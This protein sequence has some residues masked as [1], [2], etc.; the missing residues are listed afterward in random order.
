MLEGSVFKGADYF[1]LRMTFKSSRDGKVF[2][3]QVNDIV[4]SFGGTPNPQKMLPV[5]KLL[6]GSLAEEIRIH[7]IL[8]YIPAEPD[9]QT[10]SRR[11]SFYEKVDNMAAL[12]AEM[13]LGIISS[14]FTKFEF[15]C[16]GTPFGLISFSTHQEI[17]AKKF[18]SQGYGIFLGKVEDVLAR[19]DRF[20]KMVTDLV[21]G[22]QLR[23][24]M[25]VR[26]RR[27]VDGQG[28]IRVSN[29]IQGLIN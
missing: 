2:K 21:S 27:L 13:D 4:L 11:V 19:S 23:K 28:S 10:F 14:G 12:I 26:S 6:D 22:V 5:V 1:P 7:A 20:H 18:S 29:I 3:S 8:G 15:M 25:F 9:T 17:L 16:I 24:E